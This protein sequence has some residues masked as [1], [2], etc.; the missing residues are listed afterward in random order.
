VPEADE[1]AIAESHPQPLAEY[2]RRRGEGIARVEME[3]PDGRYLISYRRL[4]EVDP[5]DA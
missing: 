1:S 5:A 2:R 3:L 4:E